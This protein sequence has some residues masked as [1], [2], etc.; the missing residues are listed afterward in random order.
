MLD[1]ILFLG[2][3]NVIELLRN[4]ISLDLPAL[5]ELLGDLYAPTAA[6]VVAAGAIISIA[7]VAELLKYTIVVVLH[8]KSNR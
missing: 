3:M 1:I 5:R 7:S 2:V 4:L 6:T 8:L